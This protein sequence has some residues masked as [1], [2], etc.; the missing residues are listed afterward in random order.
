M[1]NFRMKRTKPIF[2]SKAAFV[3][4]TL[5]SGVIIFV[6]LAVLT[7][8]LVGGNISGDNVDAN[9]K[10]TES[11]G[12]STPTPSTSELP[13]MTETPNITETPKATPSGTPLAPTPTPSGNVDAEDKGTVVKLEARDY[14]FVQLGVFSSSENAEL[15]AGSIAANGGAGYILNKEGKYYIFATC[16]VSDTQAKETVLE[17]KE[18]GHSA[19]LK[20]F[21][22]NGMEITLR[23]NQSSIEKLD[24][25]FHSVITSNEKMEELI[26]RFENGELT[27][28]ELKEELRKLL[29][30]IM[31]N[32]ELFTKYSGQSVIFSDAGELS[33]TFY[34]DVSA[35]LKLDDDVRI[36][37]EMKKI[38]IKNVFDLIEYLDNV[39]IG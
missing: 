31:S 8:R 38:Y 27:R 16:S 7:G 37:S 21:S 1:R 29:G 14:Y 35:L 3:N 2:I 6:A 9:S 39:G 19:L 28:P 5:F 17:L 36:M 18:Q 15:C 22:H 23:G 20:C 10:P 34:T 32:K 24:A 33:E 25:A 11:V 13:F 4:I 26:R 30:D 12:T